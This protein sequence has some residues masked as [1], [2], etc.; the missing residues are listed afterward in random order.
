[1]PKRSSNLKLQG[2]G[3]RG[4]VASMGLVLFFSFSGPCSAESVTESRANQSESES[5]SLWRL[6]RRAAIGWSGG[7][8]NGIFGANLEVSFTALTAIE[9]GFGTAMD[10]D[11]LHFGFKRV[12]TGE[13]LLPYVAGGYGKWFANGRRR[14]L[15]RTTPGFLGERFLTDQQ[16]EEGKFALDLAYATLGLQYAWLEGDWQG[17]SLYFSGTLVATILRPRVGPML[18]LGYLYYF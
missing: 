16:R 3:A 13:S 7:G 17:S 14:G 12:L 11:T 1:M 2:R 18:G 15:E 6:H 5:E 9:A 10:Y 4:A 8:V